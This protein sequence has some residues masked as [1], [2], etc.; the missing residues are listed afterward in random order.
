M[1]KAEELAI[2]LAKAQAEESASVSSDRTM[3]FG[4]ARH[5]AAFLSATPDILPTAKFEL[6][7]G[8][9]KSSGS[10]YVCQFTTADGKVY[11]VTL[12]A[13]SWLDLNNKGERIYEETTVEEDGEGTLLPN[14]LIGVQNHQW[15]F[16]AA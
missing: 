3:V 7:K 10:W 14:L 16:M 8:R 12:D 13:G 4:K 11:N 9:K 2:A 5:D 1:T 6:F 15:V